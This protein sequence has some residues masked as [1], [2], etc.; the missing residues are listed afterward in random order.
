MIGEM[1]GK[2]VK[3]RRVGMMPG[4]VKGTLASIDKARGLLD[5]QPGVEI[6]EGIEKQIIWMRE[7]AI[8]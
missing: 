8:I 5:Y 2:E 1:L 7:A 6:R 3:V 4:D